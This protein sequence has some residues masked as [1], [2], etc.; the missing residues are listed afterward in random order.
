MSELDLTTGIIDALPA[1]HYHADPCE[2]PSLSSSIAKLLCDR[3]PRHAWT[4]HPRLNPEFERPDEQKFDVGTAAH[5]MLLDGQDICTPCDFPDWRTKA[6][7]EAR[8]Q[9]REQGRI[10]LLLDQWVRAKDMVAAV[11]AQLDQV[12][13]QPPLLTAGKPE[14]TIVWQDGGV[15]CRARIDWLRD[16]HQA[17]DDLKTTSGTANPREWAHRR[18]WDMGADIQ[19]AFYQRGLKHLTGHV[20]DFRFV[21]VETA[22]P[23]ALSVISLAPS[24]LA[25]AREKV[26]YAI[27]TWRTCMATGEWPAYA[28]RVAHAESPAWA[29]MQ[30]LEARQLDQEAKAA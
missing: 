7:R 29:E 6:A 26:D 22:P 3:S 16:D 18:L 12:D 1:D 27:S 24:A 10:P 17:V 11:R 20:P 19:V 23:Y 8:D 28:P 21:V 9:A 2:Q 14:Q 25:L 4:N 5:A 15:T 13:A 30:W